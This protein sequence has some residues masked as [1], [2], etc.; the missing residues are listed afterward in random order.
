M[1]LFGFLF[2]F[3]AVIG[4]AVADAPNAILSPAY[5]QNIPAG[6]TL[7][8][9]WTPTTPG[10]ITLTLRFGAANSLSSGTEI[11]STL[12]HSITFVPI[13]SCVL[14]LIF[15]RRHEEFGFIFV[16]YP[17]QFWLRLVHC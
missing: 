4:A 9:T 1:R 16:A 11:A 5:G 3:A 10:P 12:L 14:T 6:Q 2:T 8:I 13:E 15:R 17:I 7:S